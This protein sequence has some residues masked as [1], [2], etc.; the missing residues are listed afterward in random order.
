MNYFTV[1][2]TQL[3]PRFREFLD[4]A[5]AQ[6]IGSISHRSST[7]VELFHATSE[8]VRAVLNAP[9]DRQV[10][11]AGSATEWMERS[12]QNLSAARTLHFVSGH[13]AKRFYEF[14]LSQGRD[15]RKVDQKQDGSF[16]LADVPT[17]FAPEMIALTHNETSNGTQLSLEFFASVR[18]AFPDA[19]IALDI[20]SS[21]PIVPA[22]FMAA[23]VV[24][25]SVQKGFGMPAGLGVALVSPRAIAQAAALGASQYTGAYHSFTKLADYAA[26]GNTVET[27]NVLGIYLLNMIARD[28]CARGIDTLTKETADKA[29]LLRAALEHCIE[30][31][32]EPILPA[33]QSQ[34]VIVAKTPGGSK[35]IIERFKAAGITIA[36]GYGDRKETHVRIGNFAAHSKADMERLA[37]LFATGK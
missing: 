32:L 22:A 5:L 33:Y 34:T 15:A 13:F 16:D 36:S 35:P 20:V 31:E 9:A 7:F 26:K 12:I 23:D 14:A 24:F 1:G 17:D 27:P 8:S 4:E 25:F 3:Y 2:P 10:F 30:T 19:L 21:A 37:S 6:D 28:L 11:F 18:A 29:T